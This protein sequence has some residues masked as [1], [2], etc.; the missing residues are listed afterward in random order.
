MSK[1]QTSFFFHSAIDL[2]N[3][4]NNLQRSSFHQALSIEVFSKIF[5]IHFSFPE[6][7]TA[8][9]FIHTQNLLYL[10]FLLFKICNIFWKYSTGI[11]ILSHYLLCTVGYLSPPIPNIYMEKEKCL[12]WCSLTGQQYFCYLK[13]TWPMLLRMPCETPTSS[14]YM[15]NVSSSSCHLKSL[16]IRWSFAAI[17]QHIPFF[18]LFSSCPFYLLTCLL[19]RL[20]ILR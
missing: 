7:F 9:I 11:F 14:L 16:G 17:L 18:D 15:N 8:Q 6:L 1:P 4:L 2:T 10:R 13:S 5:L 12:L 3:K 20:C 19:Y